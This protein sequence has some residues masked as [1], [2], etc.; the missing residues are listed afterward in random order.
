MGCT[1]Q[2][3]PPPHCAG[4]A[5]GGRSRIISLGPNIPTLGG[6]GGDA[7]GTSWQHLPC[8]APALPRPIASPGS[9]SAVP[10]LTALPQSSVLQTRKIFVVKIFF[11]FLNNLFL[12]FRMVPGSPGSG[13]CC[14]F[15][16]LLPHSASQAEW[17]HCAGAPAALTS[18]PPAAP[19]LPFWVPIPVPLWA[20]CLPALS[21]HWDCAGGCPCWQQKRG[22][23]V[24][25]PE[26]CA[27]PHLSPLGPQRWWPLMLDR[28][29][30][31]DF[32]AHL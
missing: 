28:F 23:G 13:S 3:G 22:G 20:E 5:W 12:G 15:G 14:F 1:H 26:P 4:N 10:V 8:A 11:F 24:E 27:V 32:K 25:H 21:P 6:R 7:G 18:C 29:T 16:V 31:Q 9:L 19:V 2:A 30:D 17:C